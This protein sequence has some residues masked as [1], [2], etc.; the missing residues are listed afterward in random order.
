[1]SSFLYSNPIIDAVCRAELPIGITS[2]DVLLD[3]LA[4]ALNFPDY[5]GRNWDALWECIC[6]LS[7]LPPGNVIL[8]HQ[9]L[10][11]TKDVSLLCTYL[12]ILRN[13]VLNWETRGS[14][15]FYSS[16]GGRGD[17]EKCQRLLNRKFVVVFPAN[18]KET[19][20]NLLPARD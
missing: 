14:S 3:R 16:P 19:I 18:A 12:S 4:D 5:F 7:W 10:P 1:M 11:L 2:K 17:S 9:D 6:D 8:C 15:L 13:A 20:E